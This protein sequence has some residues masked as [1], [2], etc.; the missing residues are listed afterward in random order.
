[1]VALGVVGVLFFLKK[2]KKQEDREE[3]ITQ[4]MEATPELDEALGGEADIG[5]DYTPQGIDGD[6]GFGAGA[7]GDV[8]DGIWG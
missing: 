1:V 3:W 7:E 4:P 2:R 5:D 6:E 8:D